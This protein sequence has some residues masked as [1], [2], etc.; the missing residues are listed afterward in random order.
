MNFDANGQAESSKAYFLRRLPLDAAKKLFE[1]IRH[2]SIGTRRFMSRLPD[3]TTIPAQI[4]SELQTKGQRGQES[5]TEHNFS[6][7][8]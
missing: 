6:A 3:N 8:C 2:G 7:A 5:L 4:H 1:L